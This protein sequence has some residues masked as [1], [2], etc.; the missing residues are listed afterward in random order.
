M[1]VHPPNRF[2]AAELHAWT[3][4]ESK[5]ASIILHLLYILLQ[6][7]YSYVSSHKRKEIEFLKEDSPVNGKVVLNVVNNINKHCV[8]FPSI[9]G[10]TWKL[11]INGD[12]LLT[13]TE[14]GSI[15]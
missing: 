7:I 2:E 6:V 13:G 12:D 1:L 14:F 4:K 15:F 11:P 3:E 10:G 8:I 5:Q 9:D